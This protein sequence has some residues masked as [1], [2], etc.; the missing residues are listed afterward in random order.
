MIGNKHG[1]GYPEYDWDNPYVDHL[2]WNEVKNKVDDLH[3][4]VYGKTVWDHG[5]MT[6]VNYFLNFKH[7]L[8]SLTSNLPYSLTGGSL[9]CDVKATN[10]AI[11]EFLP[12]KALT[13]VS[14]VDSKQEEQTLLQ[15]ESLNLSNLN[16]KGVDEDQISFYGFNASKG[17]WKLVDERGNLL[18][19]TDLGTLATNAS[20]TS[21]F[22][23]STTAEGTVYAKYFV[24][25]NTYKLADKSMVLPERVVTPTIAIHVENAASTFQGTIETPETVTIEYNKGKAVN[26]N[27]LK[28]LNAYVFDTKGNQLDVPVTWYVKEKTCS[29]ANNRIT[30][31]EDGTYHIRAKYGNVYSDWTVVTASETDKELEPDTPDPVVP[32]PVTP[33]PDTPDPVTP[34]PDTP[35]PV[36][37]EPDTPDPVTP[38]PDTP[39][40]VTPEPDTP[41]PVVPEEDTELSY[42]EA[43]R[44][45]IDFLN[46]HPNTMR[47]QPTNL[48]TELEM[49][50]WLQQDGFLNGIYT[51]TNFMMKYNLNWTINR[52]DFGLMMFRAAFVCGYLP[53]F[54]GVFE[55]P[56]PSIDYYVQQWFYAAGHD[57]YNMKDDMYKK[58]A[59]EFLAKFE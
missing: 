14:L 52:A 42:G 17:Q 55:C 3:P 20:G 29:L 11:K 21:V 5:S 7:A 18:T 2:D 24:N 1:A 27:N 32:G 12:I 51:A 13:H 58:E 54:G 33:E 49:F 41:D 40:P 38:E 44:L 39:D 25:E 47:K 16:L 30:F 10:V 48:N 46:S 19:S 9:M 15:G 4:H 45:C 34:E 31:P 57:P 6:Y 8:N 43:C 22:K 23:A 37:P 36:T 35:D 50:E 26:L 28:N 56:R 53:Q 59:L